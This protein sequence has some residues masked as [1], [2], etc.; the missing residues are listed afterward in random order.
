[1]S[2]LRAK[3]IVFNEDINPAIIGWQILRGVFRRGV[4][5]KRLAG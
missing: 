4:L 1:M 3:A 5:G 2:R